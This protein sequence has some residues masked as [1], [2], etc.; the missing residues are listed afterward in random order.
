MFVCVC[1]CVV[2]ACAMCTRVLQEAQKSGRSMKEV[3]KEVCTLLEEIGHK[4]YLPSVRLAGFIARMAIC[5]MCSGIYI[6]QKR[7]SQVR[8]L[9]VY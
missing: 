1:V 6:N 7:I 2:C 9:F 4:F 3:E 8:M 5:R